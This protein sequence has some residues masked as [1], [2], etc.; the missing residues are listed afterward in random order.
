VSEAPFFPDPAAKASKLGPYRMA[1][2]APTP[3][4][5]PRS[6]VPA[7]DVALGASVS[8]DRN[9]DAL[10]RTQR[11]EELVADRARV[12][13]NAALQIAFGVA[14]LTAGVMVTM[15]A[16]GAVIFYGAAA[17]GVAAIMRGT[18]ALVGNATRSQ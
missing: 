14:L 5:S 2:K 18:A 4:A 9:A 1:E 12:R 13:R 16:E 7:I 15:M 17:A 11:I 3:P 8:P 6:S 10:A